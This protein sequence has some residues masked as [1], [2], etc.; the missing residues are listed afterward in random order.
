MYACYRVKMEEHIP[1]F[2]WKDDGFIY[3]LDQ[4]P[5][6][7]EVERRN[8]HAFSDGMNVKSSKP[9]IVIIHKSFLEDLKRTPVL[10]SLQGT[11]PADQGPLPS[12]REALR[13]KQI[14]HTVSV[15]KG[16]GSTSGLSVAR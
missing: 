6:Q 16:P 10:A 2:G 13:Q 7:K 12:Y 3:C 5:L 9:E 1:G 14:P 8:L 15:Q 11:H 4:H